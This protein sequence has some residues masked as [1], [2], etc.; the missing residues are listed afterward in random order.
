MSDAAA[1][2]DRARLFTLAEANELIVTVRP[3]LEKLAECKQGLEV[4]QNALLEMTPQM[5]G[6]GH[7]L[8]ALSLERQMETLV[9]R[10]AHGIREIELLGIE[11]KDIDE[12][13]IDFPSLHRGRVV[14]LCWRLG[15][16]SIG[17][18]HEMTTGFAGR[19]PVSELEQ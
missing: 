1:R 4:V 16:E 12:G 14:L 6:N 13:L 15:E 19:R 2:G 17:Y 9:D 5:R 10:L 8:E 18:W 11:L 7:R 3:L